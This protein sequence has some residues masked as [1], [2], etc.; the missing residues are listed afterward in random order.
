MP[1]L[2]MSD[3]IMLGFSTYT[4]VQLAAL[5]V[6]KRHPMPIAQMVT[7]VT[8]DRLS[9]AGGH[10]VTAD[11]LLLDNQFRS[12]ISRYYYAMYTAARAITF[13]DIQ[14]DDHQRHGVLPGKLPVSM[15]SVSIRSAE[16]NDARGLR[17]EADYDV[18][19]LSESDWESDARGLASIAA[20]FLNECETFAVQNGHV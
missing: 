5:P 10:L 18:Y 6:N 7:Q 2:T 16:L 15:P 20:K 13:A 14:G 3:Q 19:P 4:V 9:L 8:S 11:N 17:N 1:A 12:A